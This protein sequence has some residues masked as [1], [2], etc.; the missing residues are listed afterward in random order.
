MRLIFLLFSIALPAAKGISQTTSSKNVYK[1]L[2]TLETY[3]VA[4]EA[5]YGGKATRYFVNGEE[6][7]NAFTIVTGYPGRILSNASLVH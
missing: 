3:A 2:D 5:H 7:E 6:V 1:H 4:L